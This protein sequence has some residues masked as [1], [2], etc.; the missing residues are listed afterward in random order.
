MPRTNVL[1]LWVCLAA[2][3][4]AGLA[5]RAARG[6]APELEFRC[7]E[8]ACAC[9]DA[10]ACLADCCC[11][12]SNAVAPAFARRSGAHD[13][14]SFAGRRDTHWPRAADVPAEQVPAE[15]EHA[16]RAHVSG[17][18]R[19]LDVDA[20]LAPARCGGRPDERVTTASSPVPG[21][22]A[23]RDARTLQG[24][25]FGRAPLARAEPHEATTIAPPSPPPRGA[26]D[27]A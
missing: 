19:T 4:V 1:A 25:S 3:A 13:A 11:E 14:D 6:A 16:V 5:W 26:H 24:A 21:L 20:T 22:V 12:P 8:H 18:S 9:L 2:L 10:T 27:A 17:A 7:A 23:E 15:Q